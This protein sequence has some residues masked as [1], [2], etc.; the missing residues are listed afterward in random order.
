MTDHARERFE[1]AVDELRPRL[2]RYCARMTG[3]VVDGED[4][5]QDTLMKALVALPDA[6]SIDNLESYLFRIAHNTVLDFLR[7]R[8]R[9]PLLENDEALE[10]IPAPD[11]TDHDPEA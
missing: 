11:P 9:S 2:Y 10:M 3:S 5:V 8:A 4:A 1:R 7:R 6:G